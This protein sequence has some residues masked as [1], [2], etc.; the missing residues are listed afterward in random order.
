MSS[1]LLASSRSVSVFGN[2][3]K[4][5]RL[6]RHQLSPFEIYEENSIDGLLRGLTTQPSQK[7][8]VSFSSEVM[9]LYS[10]NVYPHLP[11]NALLYFS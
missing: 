9:I 8:D 5:L 2:I 3:L 4:S 7:V 11:H 1:N 10:I 6:H